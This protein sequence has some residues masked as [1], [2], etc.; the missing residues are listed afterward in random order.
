MIAGLPWESWLLLVVSVGLGLGIE[1]AFYRARSAER[2]TRESG[3]GM[4]D[5]GAP[6]G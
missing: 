6:G 5:G 2:R 4:D 3:G 1:L